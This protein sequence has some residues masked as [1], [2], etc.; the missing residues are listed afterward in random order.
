MV[1]GKN[2]EEVH[3]ASTAGSQ[4]SSQLLTAL[5]GLS[6]VY[7]EVPDTYI[8]RPGLLSQMW[9]SRPSLLPQT[10][11]QPPALLFDPRDLPLALGL[12]VPASRTPTAWG[13]TS[14]MHCWTWPPCFEPD[15]IFSA[16]SGVPREKTR[17]AG[18]NFFPVRLWIPRHPRHPPT[19]SPS[20]R[21]LVSLKAGG[22]ES[23]LGW[24][25]V[26][27]PSRSSTS[28]PIKMF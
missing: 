17:G 15:S 11:F 2:K 5:V 27:E 26:E 24:C 7:T 16:G 4:E 9:G 23:Q 12:T 14:R 13:S 21:E 20:S 10:R 18:V 28:G 22:K 8:P 1:P 6:S 3:V 25:R 19:L